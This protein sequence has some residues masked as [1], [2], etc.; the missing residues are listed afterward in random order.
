MTAPHKTGCTRKRRDSQQEF[1]ADKLV[2]AMVNPD[3]FI[4]EMLRTEEDAEETEAMQAKLE[5]NFPTE[6]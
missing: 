1:T 3:A 2:R 5:F 6:N 4:S